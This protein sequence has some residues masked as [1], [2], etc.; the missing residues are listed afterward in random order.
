MAGEPGRRAGARAP[1]RLGGDAADRGRA[2]QLRQGPRIAP[3]GA[4]RYNQSSRAGI[5]KSF[6]GEPMTRELFWLTLTVILTGLLWVPYIINRCQVRGL[7]GPMANPSR[8]DNPQADSPTPLR[9]PPHNP[10]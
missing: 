8:N 1:R 5:R 2:R 9:F 10:T 3:S 6:E 4:V 7:S